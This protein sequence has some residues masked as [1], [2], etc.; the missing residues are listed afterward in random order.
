MKIAG[1]ASHAR[2]LD[3]VLGEGRR[4]RVGLVLSG[5]IQFA[6]LGLSPQGQRVLMGICAA[7]MTISAQMATSSLPGKADADKVTLP[8][9]GS[10]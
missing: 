10:K 2:Q 9:G 6:S 4:R 7:V 5:A 3:L 1:L 8:V